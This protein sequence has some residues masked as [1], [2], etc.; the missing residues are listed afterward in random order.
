MLMSR[1]DA[2]RNPSNDYSVSS[3]LGNG[4]GFRLIVALTLRKSVTKR[5]VPSGFG[6]MKAGDPYP[7]SSSSGTLSMTPSPK[8]RNCIIELTVEVTI[9][10]LHHKRIY[11]CL[12]CRCCQWMDAVRHVPSLQEYIAKFGVFFSPFLVLETDDKLAIR[13]CVVA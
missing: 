5:T 2:H 1:A 3:I 6:T 11:R 8:S 10:D 13:F 9:L 4:H 12:I 7:E